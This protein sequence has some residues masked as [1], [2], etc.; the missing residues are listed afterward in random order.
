MRVLTLLLLCAACNRPKSDPQAVASASVIMIDPTFFACADVSTCDQ[1]CDAGSAE[2]CRKLAASYSFGRGVTKD[3]ARAAAL[4]E[5][6]CDMHDASACVFAGQMN[7]YAR[8]TDKDDAKAAKL[9]ERACA[10]EWAPGCY[11]LAIMYERGTGV[12]ADRV[13]AGQ[14]Y[15]AACK[16]GAFSACDKE[17]ALA[18]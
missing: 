1:Q 4:Y 8:G 17:R 5:H 14:L 18:R 6:A 7:E 2:S 13:K 12:A 9:Y 10:L 11:N 3:E 16:G 15:H